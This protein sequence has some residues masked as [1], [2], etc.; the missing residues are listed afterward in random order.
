MREGQERPGCLDIV[1]IDLCAGP[2]QPRACTV[3]GRPSATQV[4]MPVLL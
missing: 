1:W 4:T 2:R 3:S